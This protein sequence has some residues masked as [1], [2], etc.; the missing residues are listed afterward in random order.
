MVNCVGAG[1]QLECNFCYLLFV[2]NEQFVERVFGLLVVEQ[3]RYFQVGTRYKLNK[4]S[5]TL[6]SSS[7]SFF[8]V[9]PS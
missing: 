6:V 7:S 9:I 1:E 5:F 8:D 2:G 3:G 4:L